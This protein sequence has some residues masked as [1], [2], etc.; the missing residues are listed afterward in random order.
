[1]LNYLKSC[2]L[3]YCTDAFSSL[4]YRYHD[5]FLHTKRY[6][7]VLK[8]IERYFTTAANFSLTNILSFEDERIREKEIWNG[9]SFFS[10]WNFLKDL[11]RMKNLWAL[12]FLDF[13]LKLYW[14]LRW[15]PVHQRY[16]HQCGC[17]DWTLSTRL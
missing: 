4:W 3:L 13:C 8:G 17:I 6:W 12:A 2:K 10:L 16:Y 1:M 9:L 15:T 5:L 7:T 14:V 11:D